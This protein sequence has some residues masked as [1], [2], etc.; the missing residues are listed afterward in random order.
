EMAHV[1][2]AQRQLDDGHAEIPEAVEEHAVTRS[3]DD[4][5]ELVAREVSDEVEHVLRPAARARRDEKMKNSGRLGHDVLDGAVPAARSAT[6]MLRRIRAGS[7]SA[8]MGRIVKAT[9]HQG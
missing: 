6:R 2:P 5:L 3:G 9:H 4:H 8:S 1:Q 7:A